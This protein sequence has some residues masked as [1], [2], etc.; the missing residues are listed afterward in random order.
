MV[1]LPST[2]YGSLSVETSYQ[3]SLS[4]CSATYLPQSEIRPFS[5]TTLAPKAWHSMTFAEGVSAGMTMTAGSPAA[6][7]EAAS[8]PPAL[9]AGGADQASAPT[10]LARETT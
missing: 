3:P 9:P 8:Q 5:L 10:F 6:A 7:A 4:L 1:F 2:R